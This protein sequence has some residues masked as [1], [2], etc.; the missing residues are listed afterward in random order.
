MTIHK[1]IMDMLPVILV[2]FVV[3]SFASY[4]TVAYIVRDA[5][6]LQTLATYAP[7]SDASTSVDASGTASSEPG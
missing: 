5:F 3:T 7:V 4:V 1:R 6:W 2:F